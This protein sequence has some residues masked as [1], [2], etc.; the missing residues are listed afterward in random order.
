[1]SEHTMILDNR[2][3]MELTGVNSVNTFDDN[4]IILETKL[5]HLFIIGE[6]LHI[7]MLNL[8]EGK[9]ALEGEINSMEYKA[10]GVDL[11]TKSKN[12]LSRLLK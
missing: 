7:T 3:V 10:V 5:G 11:K 4:E 9:V 2:N 6:N 1:M 12:V 8:E